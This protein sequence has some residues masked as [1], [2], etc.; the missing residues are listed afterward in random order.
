VPGPLA[1]NRSLEWASQL[2]T[3]LGDDGGEVYGASH[4]KVV[5]SVNPNMVEDVM[6]W[7]IDQ[8]DVLWAE[9]RPTF[10]PINKYTKGVIQDSTLDASKNFLWDKGLTGAGEVV[11]C[12]DTGVD[13]DSCF[14][15]YTM[16]ANV[17]LHNV[18]FANMTNWLL[19]N[20]TATIIKTYHFKCGLNFKA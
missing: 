12:A 2:R 1:V 18:K 6:N 8:E 15:R 7:L 17:T 11:G 5:I 13:Y 20:N 10:V 3:I 9:S 4:R 16:L 14:F 19:C